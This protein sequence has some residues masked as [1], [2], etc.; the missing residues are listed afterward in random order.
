MFSKYI[1]LIA[2]AVLAYSPMIIAREAPWIG[3]DFEGKHCDGG[4][5]GFG[6]FDYTQRN[7]MMENLTKVEIHHF[8][9]EVEN[10][11]SGK[12]SRTP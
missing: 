3:G 9:P 5:Q 6:P 11:V 7:L 10:L 2:A 12:N 8:T 1:H 4:G